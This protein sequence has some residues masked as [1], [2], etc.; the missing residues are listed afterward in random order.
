MAVRQVNPMKRLVSVLAVGVLSVGVPAPSTA[1]QCYQMG[2]GSVRCQGP[3]LYIG[4]LQ[5][6][7]PLGLMPY[8]RVRYFGGQNITWVLR[9]DCIPPFDTGPDCP[10]QVAR[11]KQCP[12][13]SGGPPME[14]NEEWQAC[15]CPKPLRY[16]AIK[17]QCAEPSGNDDQGGE[18]DGRDGEG[19][20]DDAK[21]TP[22]LVVIHPAAYPSTR[23]L[24]QNI[25][26]AEQHAEDPFKYLW[27][28]EKVWPRHGEF[29][30][31][32]Q[33][34]NRGLENLGN[35]Q[36]GALGAA[37]GIPLPVLLRGAGFA[38]LVAAI[39]Q[40]A[41][42]AMSG[43]FTTRI[44]YAPHWGNFMFGPPYG[45][46]PRDQVMI[47]FGYNWYASGGVNGV[48]Q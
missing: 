7:P 37:L 45:D 41:R 43:T 2:D 31:K 20:G 23:E 32:Y 17:N 1:Q 18:D 14:W 24:C 9:R 6:L 8:D 39:G 5:P 26:L 28:A 3:G 42:N 27:F 21:R 4:P 47:T 25:R 13:M 12:E 40:A 46:D 44:G 36:F 11:R 30:L 10:S 38:Q 16:D 19:G 15:T 35:T 22:Q 29:D 48:C 33:Y 34:N